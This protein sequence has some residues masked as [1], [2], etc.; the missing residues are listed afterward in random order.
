MNYR[1]PTTAAVLKYR[2]R[3]VIT[4]NGDFLAT[5]NIGDTARVH[6]IGYRLLY[7]FFV[8][9]KK[10]LTIDGAFVFRILASVDDV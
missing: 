1:T 7:V 2:F 8:S 3:D 9:I 4:R 6:R 10:A 5:L